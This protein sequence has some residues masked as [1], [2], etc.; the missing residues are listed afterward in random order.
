MIFRMQTWRVVRQMLLAVV[1]ILLAVLIMIGLAFVGLDIAYAGHVFKGVSVEG[2]YI[3]SM[4][5]EEA[6]EKLRDRLD[7]ET[8][9]SDLLLVFDGHT[10]PLPLYEIDAYVDIEA[11]VDKALQAGRDVPFY[12][13]WASRAIFRGLD[14]D[15]DLIIYYDH[16]KLD[17]FLKTLESIINREPMNAEIKLQG[18]NLVY[19]RSQQGWRLDS[20]Q[21]HLSILSALPG[22]ER[23]AE[24]QIEVTPPEVSDEQLGK[25]ITVDKSSYTLTLYNNMEIE[26]QYPVAVG[27]SSW[28]TPS[29]TYKV[30]VMQ[31]NPTWV[32]PGTS[33][34]TTMPPYIPAGSGNPLGTRAIGTSA[35]GVFIHGT[36]SSYSIGTSASHG[37]IRMYIRDSEDLFERVSVGLPVLIY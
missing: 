7:L 3:G 9:N 11:T 33:W 18:R 4:S 29:G 2:V 26:K 30:T 35:S 22:E 32:N 8:L 23:I 34:A 19:Q 1:V 10:W 6:I 31:R 16:Q 37:C 25:V 20:E 28:P 14:R 5:R 21:A 12:E 17:S 27:M 24:I 36:Y 13:R 15:V